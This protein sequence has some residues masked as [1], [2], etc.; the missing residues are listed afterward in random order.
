M[1]VFRPQPGPQEAFLSTEADVAF[2]GGAAG[3]GKTYALILEPLRHFMN[4]QFGAVIFRRLST[5]ITGEGGLWDTALGVYPAMGAKP[6]LNPRYGFRF[7][8]GMK[9]T[10]AH[11]QF[12]ID[13]QA[14]QG[15]QIPMIGFDELTHF[16]KHQFFYMLSRNRSTCGVRPYIRA[17]CNPDVDSWVAEFI[18]WWIDPETGY[19]IPKRAGVVRYFT[20]LAGQVIWGATREEVLEQ[21]NFTAEQIGDDDPRD[22][23]KSFTFIPSKLEDNTILMK[24]DPGY[25]GSLLALPTVERERL[26]GGN[27]KIRKKKGDTFPADKVIIIP[28]VPTGIKIN[29]VRRWDLAG[30][31]PSESNPDPD[32]TA[33]IVMGL[34]SD[35][36]VIIVDGQNFKEDPDF[37]EKKVIS[38]A[39]VDRKRYGVRCRTI[40]GED[41]GQAGKAQ[42]L[43]YIKKLSGYR[44]EAI[45][46]TGDKE[47]RATLLS[48]QWHAGNVDVVDGPWVK[49]YLAEMEMFPFKG[50]GIHDDYVDASSGA[51]VALTEKMLASDRFQAMAS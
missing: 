24:L 14:W 29:W 3:G 25:K 37:V 11:L 27:W 8:S 7:K 38:T 49:K 46:E 2:Y 12:E 48:A 50:S 28:A 39:A 36:R 22:L 5:Q 20:Q 35:R 47:T 41:P 42:A 15:S 26:L 43:A 19:P 9:L 1:T 31:K 34:T 18:E 21:V 10:F 51:Y 45:R 32:A 23:V 6:F 13:T 40:L 16:T 17:T 30:T 33:S 4:S 44:V